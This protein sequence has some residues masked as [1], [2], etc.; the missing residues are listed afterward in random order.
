MKEI[1]KVVSKKLFICSF[2]VNTLFSVVDYGESFVLAFLGTG[3][4]TLNKLIFVT[5]CIIIIEII[6][7]IVCKLGSYID[8]INDIKTQNS[9][10][11][12]YFKKM[13]SMSMEQISNIHTGYIH[14]LITNTARYFFEMTWNFEA[15][16]VPLFI[17]GIS[18]MVMIFRQS[19]SIGFICILIS[20]IAVIAN[21]KL[22]KNSKNIRKNLMKHL[23]NIMLN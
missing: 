6:K 2:I 9:I 12:Y 17:G 8:N 10:E 11:I 1:L 14:K 15:S 13:Q 19:I 23:Q 3:T 22:T 20:S 7:L 4:L 5:V 18:I 21:Y 16:V